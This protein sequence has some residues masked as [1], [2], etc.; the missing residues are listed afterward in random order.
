MKPLYFIVANGKPINSIVEARLKSLTVTDETGEQS[1]RF[2]LVLEDSAGDLEMPKKGA[3]V[4]ISLGLESLVPLG[5]FTV[6]TVKASGPPNILQIDGS[7]APF[8]ASGE[9]KGMQSRK[10][11]SFDEKTIGDIV[12]QIAGEHGLNPVVSDELASINPGHLDQTDEGDV[13]FLNRIARDV[14]GV[15]KATN[16]RL[17][18]V[19]R[20]ASKT[21]SGKTLPTV[22]IVRTQSTR[23]EFV[24]ADRGG[25][26]SAVATY[27]DAGQA[28]TIEVVVGDGD[29]VLRLPHIYSTESNARRAATSRLKDAERSSGGKLTISMPGR[30]DVLAESPIAVSGFRQGVDGSFVVRRVEHSLSKSGLTTSIDAESPDSKDED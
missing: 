27:R 22:A 26:K 23:W 10:S 12:K 11:R 5:T 29:P 20:G 16:D 24:A 14:G 15:V 6:D 8:S 18:F 3:L 13:S 21:A 2:S 28:K 9:R 1:D 4:S 30:L 17:A 25:Y 7:A 19:M